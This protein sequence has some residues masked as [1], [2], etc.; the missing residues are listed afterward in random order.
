MSELTTSASP[1]PA[2]STAGSSTSGSSTSGSSALPVEGDGEATT[3]F[4]RRDGDL[5]VPSRHTEGP[6][7]PET[8]AGNPIAALLAWGVEQVPTL[9]PM[10]TVRCTFDLLRPSPMRP[11]EL[12]TE[13]VREGKRIQVVDASLWVDGVRYAACRALRLRR[14]EVGP[15]QLD[16]PVTGPIEMPPPPG[17][18]MWD[19]AVVDGFPGAVRAFEAKAVDSDDARWSTSLWVRLRIPVIDGVPTS[20]VAR[21]AAI[22]D[23]VSN[24]VSHADRTRWAMINADLNVA[25]F[26]E[27]TSDWL[28]LT[29]RTGFSVDGIGHSVGWIQDEEGHVATA[30]TLGMVE[31]ISSEV[32]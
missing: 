31:P 29:I 21:I 5:F 15:P 3:G 28:A 7:A 20:A 24:S 16:N 22:S 12:R 1:D 30:M 25:V 6:W 8:Q 10:R 19:L 18:P 11:M 17:R 13:V 9:A 26:R 23:F 4:Y 32:S 2:S 14:G 27:P